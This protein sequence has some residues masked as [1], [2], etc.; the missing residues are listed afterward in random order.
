MCEF[1]SWYSDLS[2]KVHFVTDKDLPRLAALK[3][4]GEDVLGHGAIYALRGWAKDSEPAGL[5]QYECTDFSSPDNFPPEI[6][7]AI[8]SGRMTY[9]PADAFLLTDSAQAEYN[10]VCKAAFQALW[11]KPSN[12][13]EAWR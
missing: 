4:E 1:V 2:G 3:V 7:D 11:A 10:R 6:A 5:K 12:R 8:K 13:I 9:G